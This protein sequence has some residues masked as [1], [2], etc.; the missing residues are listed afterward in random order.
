MNADKNISFPHKVR[1]KGVTATI[2]RREKNGYPEYRVTWYSGEQR[3]MASFAGYDQAHKKALEICRSVASGNHANVTLK[4]KDA[5]IYQ[6]AIDTL[7]P[8]GIPLDLAVDRS[9]PRQSPSSEKSRY[10]TLS[11]FTCANT[12]RLCQGKG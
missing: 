6:R 9:M 12:P 7:K 1:E 10:L 5:A 11:S 4:S 3:K 8:F 2:Y